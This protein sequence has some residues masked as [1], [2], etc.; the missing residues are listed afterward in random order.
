MPEGKNGKRDALAIAGELRDIIDERA[1][2]GL[3]VSE[4]VF[5]RRGRPLT[6]GGMDNALIR[7]KRDLGM[8][9]LTLHGATRRSAI[10]DRRRDGVD[11]RV[12]MSLSGHRD[13]GV[14]D[15][16]YN[17]AELRD[18]AEALERAADRGKVV[19]L[20]EARKRRAAGE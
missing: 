8:P 7:A 18:Q 2:Q 17:L 5:H 15:Q 1:Q 6:K 14:F 10:I 19:S 11:D 3:A 16:H 9:D 4:Y 20:D 13:R 12:S